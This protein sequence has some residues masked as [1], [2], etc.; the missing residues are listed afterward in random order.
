MLGK[1][2]IERDDLRDR[3]AD[4]KH[5]DLGAGRRIAMRML[6]GV[7]HLLHRLVEQK[8]TAHDQD[9]VLPG[10]RLLPEVEEWRGQLHD[11]RHASQ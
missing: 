8:E 7:V 11:P 10:D 9:Q 1:N 5:G 4:G 2:Q 6:D 3:T